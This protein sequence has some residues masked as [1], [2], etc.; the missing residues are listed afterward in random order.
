MYTGYAAD[1]GQMAL[2][3]FTGLVLNGQALIGLFMLLSRM[4]GV[5]VGDV[6]AGTVVM[7]DRDR[8]GR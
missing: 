6:F 4:S 5:S 8:D 2:R 3:Q 1:R 7:R